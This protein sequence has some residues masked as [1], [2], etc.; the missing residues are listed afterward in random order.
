M[1]VVGIIFSIG[2]L[3]VIIYLAVSPKS[4]K[5]LRLSAIIALG[6]ICLSILI[7]GIVIIKGPAADPME[8]PLP[9]F[10]DSASPVKK[11]KHILDI[12]ILAVLLAALSLVIAKALKDQR[13]K[14]ENPLKP[15]EHLDFPDEVLESSSPAGGDTE[16]SFEL[17][18]LDFK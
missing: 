1:L 13:K 7:C 15:S 12:V 10:Q 3:G 5:L 4:S 9:V 17:D 8:I 16:D 14:A 18:D 11:D 2:L 6:L